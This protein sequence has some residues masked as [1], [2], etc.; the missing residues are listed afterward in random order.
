M[1]KSIDYIERTV[2]S[3]EIFSGKVV[4]LL[5]DDVEFPD[6]KR[7]KREVV[8]H[9]GGVCILAIDNDGKVLMERQ[10]RY[11]VKEVIFELPA[12]KLEKGEDPKEA[13]IRELKEETGAMSESFDYLGKMY[14][15]VG[16][17][18][19]IIWF[20]VAKGLTFGE[21]CFD[22]HEFVEVERWDLKELLSMI[23][24]GEIKDAKT[25]FALTTYAMQEGILKY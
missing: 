10:Y 22:E 7:S 25:V 23:K 24:N 8:S 9:N 3:N 4:R 16:Y 15:T 1:E 19:E 2:K 11:A 21:N 14:P 17:D 18:N 12:G 6:G 5:V 13:G 20:Y